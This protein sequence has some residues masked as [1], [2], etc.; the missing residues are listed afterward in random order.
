MI[1]VAGVAF[2]RLYAIALHLWPLPPKATSVIFQ[3]A[4]YSLGL[5]QALTRNVVIDDPAAAGITLH[6]HWFANAHVSATRSISGLPAAEVSFH[7][8]LVGMLL[9]LCWSRPL[10][11]SASSRPRVKSPADRWPGGPAPWQP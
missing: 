5:S 2:I 4:W 6:Y 10:R 8:W 7:L 9:T 11:P 1:V 3:D